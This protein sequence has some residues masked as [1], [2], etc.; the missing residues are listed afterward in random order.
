MNL[1]KLLVLTASAT[2]FAA[3]SK[4][5]PTGTTPDTTTTKK[6]TDTVAVANWGLPQTD[7]TIFHTGTQVG[8]YTSGAL[9]AVSGIAASREYPGMFWLENDQGDPNVAIYLVDTSGAIR[10]DY[11]VTGATN[12]DW[13]DMT[14]G[15]GPGADTT[16][17]YI[18]DIGDSPGDHPYSI[19]YRFPEPNMPLGTTELYGNTAHADQIRYKYPSPDGPHDAETILI[20]PQSKDI[21][22]VDKDVNGNLYELP[23]PQSTDT[24]I[25]ATKLLENLHFGPW[26]CGAIGTNRK[27]LILKGY[28]AM[29]YWPI[30]PGES[31]LDVLLSQPVYISMSGINEPKGEA[32]CLTPNDSAIWTTSK[33][34]IYTYANLDRFLRK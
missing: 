11:A 31:I 9:S 19:V 17:V 2:L 13:T 18:A 27:D 14:I 25:T 33:F 3:C 20:D 23:Y 15:P 1:T 21:Y 5:S 24:I 16:Y 32:M 10:A 8:R 12:R 6:P 22:I 26:R 30:S 34:D 7:T 28:T 29:M 4:N